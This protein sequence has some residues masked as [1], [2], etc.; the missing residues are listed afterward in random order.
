MNLVLVTLPLEFVSRKS[1]GEL[2]PE[3]VVLTFM[4]RKISVPADPRNLSTIKI[5]PVI[6]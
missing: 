2:L 1:G 5:T 4:I 3:M 6:R